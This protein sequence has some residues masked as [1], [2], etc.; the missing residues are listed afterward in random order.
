ML[1]TTD[2]IIYENPDIDYNR[3]QLNYLYLNSSQLLTP[4]ETSQIV[5]FSDE[6]FISVNIT[7]QSSTNFGDIN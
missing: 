2:R 6:Y 5:E 1:N 4:N 3:L 7:Y